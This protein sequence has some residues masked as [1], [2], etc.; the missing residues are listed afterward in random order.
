[1]TEFTGPCSYLSFS[2]IKCM[3][4]A[5]QFL[6]TPKQFIDIDKIKMDNNIINFNFINIPSYYD[7]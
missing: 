6:A 4:F 1:M 7:S 5:L 3:F 2:N